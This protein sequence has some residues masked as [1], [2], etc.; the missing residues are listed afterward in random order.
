MNTTDL[1][2]ALHSSSSSFSMI[3]R[4]CASSAENGS[5][6]SRIAGIEDQH[7]RERHALAH[8]ARELVRIAILEA[9]EAR[10]ARATRVPARAPRRA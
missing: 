2:S 5:S 3:W 6:I 1:R 4:V 9:G 7:L 8:A 10:R